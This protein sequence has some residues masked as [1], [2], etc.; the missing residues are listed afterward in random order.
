VVEP[1]NVLLNAHGHIVLTD[2]G[3]ARLVDEKADPVSGEVNG[4]KD[5]FVGTAEYVCPELLQQKS[6]GYAMDLWS[7][8][9]LVFALLAGR[10][11]FRGASQYLTFQKIT[12]REFAFPEDFPEVAKDLVDQLLVLNPSDRLGAGTGGYSKLKAHP[13]F[14]SIDFEN[15]NN[16]VAPAFRFLEESTPTTPKFEVTMDFEEAKMMKMN[17]YSKSEKSKTDAHQRWRRFLVQDEEITK[18]G[19]VLKR[20]G[21]FAKRRMLILTETPRFV[22]I[23]PEKMERRGEITWSESLWAE[24]KDATTFHIHTP[25][26]TYYMQAQD[27]GA[28]EWVETINA[29][30]KKLKH[31]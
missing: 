11:P 12:A 18:L 28:R 19:Y 23:D 21:L 4:R 6:T 29:V 15:I 8:G 24:M 7:L 31:K 27:I 26:R 14:A 22:Y 25:N 16:Q 2:F 20:S 13:F 17:S 10:P 9:C 5:S 1:E 30:N 3:T